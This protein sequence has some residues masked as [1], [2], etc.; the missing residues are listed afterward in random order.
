MSIRQ[1]IN[2]NPMMVGL[3]SGGLVLIAI[4]LVLWQ[5]FGGGSSRN[6]AL[7]DQLFYSDDDGKTF[8]PA[9]NSNIAPF[10]H[11]G[12]KAYQA[13]VY[14]CGSN[15]PFVAFLIKYNDEGKRQMESDLKSGTKPADV[16]AQGLS[17]A[18]YKGPGGK[19]WVTR[20]GD[21]MEFVHLTH[22]TC[23]DGGEPTHLKGGEKT[24]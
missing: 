9:S 22:P 19:K 8:F 20:R 15:K 2:D 16:Y 23:P 17:Y 5:L 11:N 13:E 4:L 10:D 6:F 1:K 3:I 12:K 7:P 14:R 21:A 18:E 24:D